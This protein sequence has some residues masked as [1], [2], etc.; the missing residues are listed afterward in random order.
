VIS[1]VEELRQ[2][3]PARLEVVAGRRGSRLAG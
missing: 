3:I 1:H 2:R